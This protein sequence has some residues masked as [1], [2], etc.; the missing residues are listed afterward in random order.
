MAREHARPAAVGTSFLSENGLATTIGTVPRKVRP[1]GVRWRT[2]VPRS[3]A[4]SQLMVAENAQRITRD[5]REFLM[6]HTADVGTRYD[7]AKGR[8]RSDLEE[9]VRE[10]YARTSEWFL[11]IL[12]VSD[13]SVDYRPILRA[14]LASDGCSKKEVDATDDRNEERVIEAIRAKRAQ[15]A[16]APVP[17]ASGWVW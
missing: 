6:G 12:T 1:A 7:L 4:S 11:R 17:K 3:F 8:T 15:S 2:Y 10:A 13:A 16:S 14:L 5:E 9:Q